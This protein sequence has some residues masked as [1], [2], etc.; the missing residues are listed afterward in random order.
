L[1]LNFI[2]SGS[3]N[4]WLLADGKV[5]DKIHEDVLLCLLLWFLSRLQPGRWGNPRRVR[6]P[7]EA[8]LLRLNGNIIG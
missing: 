6:H 1:H 4:V 7:A 3:I 8:V 2:E 5:H